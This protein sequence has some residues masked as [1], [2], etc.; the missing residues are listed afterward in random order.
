MIRNLFQKLL[1]IVCGSVISLNLVAKDETAGSDRSVFDVFK[2]ISAEN[3]IITEDDFSLPK[4]NENTKWK[5]FDAGIESRDNR[6]Y[7]ALDTLSQGKRDQL[8]RYA[9]KFVTPGG[10]ENIRFEALDCLLRV[11]KVYAFGNPD[12][13]WTPAASPHWQDIVRQV[14]NGYQ[15]ELYD[16]F[17]RDTKVQSIEEIKRKFQ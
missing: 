12:G 9:V 5:T 11:Y 14:R 15:A 10:A 8:F 2:G 13:S 1:W 6:F 16:A 17:C 4:L 7:L 3:V